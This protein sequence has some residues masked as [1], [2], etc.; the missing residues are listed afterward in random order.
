[1]NSR[2]LQR[3]L[4]SSYNGVVVTMKIKVVERDTNVI[5][6]DECDYECFV[7]PP[8]FHYEFEEILRIQTHSMAKIHFIYSLYKRVNAGDAVLREVL[9]NNDWFV[10]E[11]D[12]K[13]ALVTGNITAIDEANK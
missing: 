9:T 10:E 12:F 4:S 11:R 5:L 2:A 6:I 3:T 13:M 7:Q 1:M 8:P